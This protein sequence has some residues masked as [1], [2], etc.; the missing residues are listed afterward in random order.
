MLVDELSALPGRIQETLKQTK[1]HIGFRLGAK[2]DL[3]PNATIPFLWIVLTDTSFLLC[4]THKTRG[5]FAA[6]SWQTINCV[7]RAGARSI[8]VIHQSL[9]KETDVLPLTESMREDEIELLLR[10]CD[11]ATVRKNCHT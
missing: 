2:T 5:V 4:S 9:D 1:N 7:R 10:V 11:D 6:Y 8:E 3:K